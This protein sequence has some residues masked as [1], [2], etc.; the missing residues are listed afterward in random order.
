MN[1]NVTMIVDTESLLRD[2]APYTG[3]DDWM[4]ISM[5]TPTRIVWGKRD[6]RFREVARVESVEKPIKAP[7]S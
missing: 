1:Y 3:P 5:P 6:L 4:V 7:Q 2:A